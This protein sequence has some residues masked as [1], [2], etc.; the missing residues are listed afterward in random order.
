M[1]IRTCCYVL[2]LVIEAGLFLVFLAPI[3]YT[4]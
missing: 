4:F 2:L 1:Q 3:F